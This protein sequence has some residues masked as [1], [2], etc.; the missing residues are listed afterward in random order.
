MK[1]AQAF[2]KTVEGEHDVEAEV[3]LLVEIFESILTSPLLSHSLIHL[4]AGF[5]SLLLSLSLICSPWI[6]SNVFLPAPLS[7][8]ALVS[9]IFEFVLNTSSMVWE[10]EKQVENIYIYAPK[11]YDQ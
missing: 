5:T 11:F 8:D 3:K 10:P 7:Q 1:K 9:L 6:F 2:R 4:S